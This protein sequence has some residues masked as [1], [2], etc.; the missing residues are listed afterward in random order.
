MLDKTSYPQVIESS[1]ETRL[2]R[3]RTERSELKLMLS[4]N[5]GIIIIE[6]ETEGQRVQYLKWKPIHRFLFMALYF[7]FSIIESLQR[8]THIQVLSI[9]LINVNKL[10]LFVRILWFLKTEDGEIWNETI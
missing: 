1:E 10:Y 2:G 7:Y 3:L 8:N 6:D 5:A 9:Y 4:L